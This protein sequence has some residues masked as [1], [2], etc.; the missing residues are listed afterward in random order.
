MC[1][2]LFDPFRVKSHWVLNLGFHS[3]R[4]FHPRLYR[5]VA[6]GDKKPTLTWRLCGLPPLF[7]AYEVLPTAHKTNVFARKLILSLS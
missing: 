2:Y 5:Y 3:L 6:F 1:A 4:S 7:A